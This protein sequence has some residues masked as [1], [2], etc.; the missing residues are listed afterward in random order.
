[1]YPQGALQDVPQGS[2][3]DTRSSVVAG[4][5]GRAKTLRQT[6]ANEADALAAARAEWLRI[7]RGIY[8]FD[9][10]LAYGPC[11]SGR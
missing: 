5:S 4:I 11:P 1:M 10:T 8:S 9:I 2:G 6:Y 7:Q 3:P